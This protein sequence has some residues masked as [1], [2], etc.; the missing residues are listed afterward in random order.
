VDNSRTRL[1]GYVLAAALGAVAGGL[2]VALVSRTPLRLM[3]GMMSKKMAELAAEGC[4]P[5][6]M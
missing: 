5:E 4:D 6:E 3:S 2:A 1:A